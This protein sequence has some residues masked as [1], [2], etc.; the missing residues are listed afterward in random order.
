MSD[1]EKSTITSKFVL[2]ANRSIYSLI[3][4]L[5]VNMTSWST[6]DEKT[7]QALN[8]CV[9]DLLVLPENAAAAQA[10]KRFFDEDGFD[11]KLDS[12]KISMEHNR[13][14]LIFVHKRRLFRPVVTFRVTEKKAPLATVAL[15]Q[16]REISLR[17][18]RLSNR[19]QRSFRNNGIETFG[20][21]FDKAGSRI[22]MLKLPQIGTRAVEE[23]ESELNA[24]GI[25]L[26]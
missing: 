22:E 11:Y 13:F 12:V 2:I 16:V 25:A 17:D 20:D 15:K 6:T 1:N 5:V 19:A 26:K 8:A 23:I 3:L 21:L 7:Q 18:T 10:S 14:D 9:K 4:R 24:M